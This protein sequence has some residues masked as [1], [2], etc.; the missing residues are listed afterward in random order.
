MLEGLK[1][2]GVCSNVGGT[3][4]PLVRVGLTYLTK[5]GGGAPASSMPGI[6]QTV[7][8]RYRKEVVWQSVPIII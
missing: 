3:I 4:C 5:S 6:H 2:W 1:I 7:F 8:S